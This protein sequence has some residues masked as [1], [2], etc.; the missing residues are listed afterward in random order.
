ML[1]L[2]TS[3]QMDAARRFE[4]EDDDEND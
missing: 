1:G 3:S 2:A 4:D